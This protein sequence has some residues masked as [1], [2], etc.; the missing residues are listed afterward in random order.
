M[1]TPAQFDA[2]ADEIIALFAEY[3]ISVIKDVARRLRNLDFASAA[4]QVQ[5][6][7]E[8]GALYENVL[9]QLAQ[10]TGMSESQVKMILQNAGVNAIKFDDKIYKAAGLK[11]LPLN[12]SPAMLQAL[13]AGIIKTNGVITNLTKTTAVAAQQAFIHASDLA[14]LQ[15]STGAMSY[16]EAIRAAIKKVAT[17]GLDVIQYPTG[18]KDKLDVAVRRAIITGV[19][20]TAGQLQLIRAGE[21]GVDLIQVSAHVGARN[22]GDGPMNHESWQ[23]RVYSTKPHTEY[24]D[25]VATTGY[26]TGEGLG[27]W[28]CRHSFYPFFDGI[29]ENAYTENELKSFANQTVTF[30]GRSMSVYEG[31]QIQ[32]GIERRIRRWKRQAAALEAAGLDHARESAKVQ[33][34]QSRMRDF[35]KQTG[36]DRQR[37]REQIIF[38]GTPGT[39]QPPRA[40]RPPVIPRPPVVPVAPAPRVPEIP[41]TSVAPVASDGQSRPV[42]EALDTSNL[43]HRDDKQQVQIALNAI[44]KVHNDGALPKIPI[45]PGAQRGSYGIFQF[46]MF[47]G[48]PYK[49]GIAHRGDHKALTTVHEIGHFL[50]NSGTQPRWSSQLTIENNRIIQV[51]KQTNWWTQFRQQVEDFGKSLDMPIRLDPKYL[52]YIRGEKEIFARAYAQFIAVESGD[53]ILLAQLKKL[54]DDSFPTQWSDKDFEPIAEEF[55]KLFRERGWMP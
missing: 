15:V 42:S 25:F 5:R 54:Q 27:G 43:K 52:A 18:H 33:L 40:P 24:K 23:G 1:L 13:Q 11:P 12:L 49:I 35:V 6:I 38:V 17:D 53:P 22:V 3:E 41:P 44:D 36:L 16:D 10:L 20:Q 48:K 14:Y 2:L 9:K 45:M 8:S 47:T 28:N 29:S 39:P 46:D 51:A 31:T 26:G 34:W 32:R 55:R 4:W 30:N 21:L 7:T 19:S 50:D 37:V